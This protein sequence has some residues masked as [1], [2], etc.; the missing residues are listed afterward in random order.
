MQFGTYKKGSV[1]KTFFILNEVNR[2]RKLID[3]RKISNLFSTYKIINIFA[4]DDKNI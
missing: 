4:P 3:I 2:K 1:F